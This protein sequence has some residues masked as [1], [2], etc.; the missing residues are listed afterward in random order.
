[1]EPKIYTENKLQSISNGEQT[2]FGNLNT[3]VHLHITAT[4]VHVSGIVVLPY[5]KS[6]K[7]SN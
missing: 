2:K 3:I 7:P 4:S 1:M 5:F 6:Q